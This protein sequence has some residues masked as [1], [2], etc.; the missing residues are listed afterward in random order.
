VRHFLAHEEIAGEV[1]LALIG[2]P[3]ELFEV[4]PENMESD[5]EISTVVT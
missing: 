4:S 5:Y 3:Q 2:K 1:V